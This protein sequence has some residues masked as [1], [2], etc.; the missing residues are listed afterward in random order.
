MR[1]LRLKK[2]LNLLQSHKELRQETDPTDAQN[3]DLNQDTKDPAPAHFP[4]L[5]GQ[6]EAVR[7]TPFPGFAWLL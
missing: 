2:G 1:R 7:V 5:K 4:E 3:L 6:D